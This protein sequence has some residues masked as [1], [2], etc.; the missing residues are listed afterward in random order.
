[1]FMFQIMSQH[2]YYTMTH[3]VDLL[4]NLPNLRKLQAKSHSNSLFVGFTAMF[5]R[6]FLDNNKAWPIQGFNGLC[7]LGSATQQLHL[8][9]D[10]KKKGNLGHLKNWRSVALLCLNYKILSAS[11]QYTAKIYEYS[12][13]DRVSVSGKATEI[14]DTNCLDNYRVWL[15][16]ELLLCGRFD[17]SVQPGQGFLITVSSAT[18]NSHALL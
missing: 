10:C 15:Y 1:M 16:L 4:R 14:K 17:W 13:R 6:I 9:N 8:N 18:V 3:S 11:L 2:R 7:K 12:Q 5:Y